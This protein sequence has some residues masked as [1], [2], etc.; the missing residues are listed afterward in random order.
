METQRRGR[1]VFGIMLIVFALGS[2]FYGAYYFG[3]KEAQKKYVQYDK[4]ADVMDVKAINQTLKSEEEGAVAPEGEIIKKGSITWQT[5]RD[6]GNLGLCN[7]KLFLGCDDCN[8]E[9]YNSIGVKYVKSG[10]FVDG[11]YAGYDFIVIASGIYEGP[12]VLPDI[13]RALRKEKEIIFLTN[14]MFGMEDDYYVKF[15]QSVFNEGNFKVSFNDQIVIEDLFFPDELYGQNDRIRFKRDVYAK[16][17]FTD[18]KLREAFVSEKY[19]QVWV[20]DE[21][22]AI[23]KNS[24][25][26]ELNSYYS[27]HNKTKG[28]YDIF[29]R[30][31]FYVKSPDGTVA[32]YSLKFDIF[33]KNE[34]LGVLQAIW[35][36]G[37]KNDVEYE[38]NPSGCG[39]GDYVYIETL[40]FNI[41]KDLALIGKTAQGDSL[42]GFKDINSSDFQ[43]IY[44]EIYWTKEGEKKKSQEEFLKMNPKVFWVDPFGRT[45]SFYR[46][47]IISPAECGKPVIYLYPETDQEVSVKVFPG[48]GLSITDPEYKDGWNVLARKN[49][50]LINLEDQKKYPYL[51]W[52]GAGDVYYETPKQGFTVTKENLDSFFDEKL[53]K[54]GMI[55]KEIADFKEFWIPEM[56]KE[57]KPYYFVTFLSKRF[58]DQNAPLVIHPKPDSIIRVLMDFRGLDKPEKFSQPKIVTPERKGFTVVEWGGMLK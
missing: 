46:A 21:V 55:G 19:G 10:E 42:Y 2:V 4:D 12:S 58:I 36:D 16:A 25:P 41:E 37:S 23:N 47:D 40:N 45:L 9:H 1:K 34:R 43:K 15:I 8:K 29:N 17:F 26:F 35:N 18:Q 53:E 28:Y 20:T 38:Q 11:K 7:E 49:G 57:N 27:P 14:K 13:F 48:K 39:A 56:L 24:T 44:N 5:P 52:E 6:I 51:F 31:G 50:E 54:L 30:H 32:A 3:Q 22:K 33:D